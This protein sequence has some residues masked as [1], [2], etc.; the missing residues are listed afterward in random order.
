MQVQNKAMRLNFD[1]SKKSIQGVPLGDARAWHRYFDGRDIVA[2]VVP[3]CP[4]QTVQ[5]MHTFL[6]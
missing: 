3:V 1:E 2:D 6:N 5:V 4:R